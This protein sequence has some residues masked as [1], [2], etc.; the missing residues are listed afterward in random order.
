MISLEYGD[1][2]EKFLLMLITIFSAT[3]SLIELSKVVKGY[4]G[5]HT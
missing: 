1:P 3:K 2:N 5:P 4:A